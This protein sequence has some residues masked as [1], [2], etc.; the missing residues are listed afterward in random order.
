MIF[1]IFYRGMNNLKF[2]YE[3]YLQLRTLGLRHQ[4]H[5]KL[6]LHLITQ[7]EREKEKEKEEKERDRGKGII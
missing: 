6:N 7:R 5:A 3:I 4:R 2:G 1:C